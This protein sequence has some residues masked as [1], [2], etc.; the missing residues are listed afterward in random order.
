MD[1]DI[2]FANFKDGPIRKKTG[3]TS[4]YSQSKFVRFYCL[5]LVSEFDVPLPS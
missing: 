5:S 3:T 1:P 4:L 2:N